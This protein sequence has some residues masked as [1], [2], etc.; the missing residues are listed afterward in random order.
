MK[1]FP[2]KKYLP[3]LLIC[4]AILFPVEKVK[5][6]C[7]IC[8]THIIGSDSL[9]YTVSIG[10]TLC[11]DST[12]ILKGTIVLNGGTI[13]NKGIFNPASVTFTSGELHNYGNAQVNFNSTLGTSLTWINYGGSILNLNG[14]LTVSGG[15][16]SNEGIL[17]VETTLTFS[18]GT[19][20]NQNI[21]NCAT[22]AG[23]G[24]ITNTGIIN[25]N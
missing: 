19:F 7:S 5:A 25:S 6:Q 18:S 24:T 15:S 1:F 2:Y 12:G 16:F 4:L 3:G 9:T 13:C 20:S 14:S 21:I 10:Q 23:S 11:V 17:N 8:T 22:L